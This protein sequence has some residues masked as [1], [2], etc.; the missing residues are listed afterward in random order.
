MRQRKSLSYSV[1]ETFVAGRIPITYRACS[2]K[3]AQSDY[4]S[5]INQPYKRGTCRT[6]WDFGRGRSLPVS[7]KHRGLWMEYDCCGIANLV[8]SRVIVILPMV[9]MYFFQQGY[10]EKTKNLIDE[11]AARRFASKGLEFFRSI[12]PRRNFV[13]SVQVEDS[14]YRKLRTYVLLP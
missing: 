12:R 5:E 7:G 14:D 3:T 11:G 6:V 1:T 8:D 9:T 2:P 4:T 13:S 10:K